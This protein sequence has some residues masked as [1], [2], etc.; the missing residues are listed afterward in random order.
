MRTSTVTAVV[1]TCSVLVLRRQIGTEGEMAI[2]RT[3]DY[4]SIKENDG[5]ETW[6]KSTGNE[7][8][9]DRDITIA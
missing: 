4:V 2:P 9:E 7:R 3:G 1:E 5:K 6:A 8:L